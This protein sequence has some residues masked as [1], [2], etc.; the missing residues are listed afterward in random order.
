MQASPQPDSLCPGCGEPAL[1]GNVGG[2]QCVGCDMGCHARPASV[3]FPQKFIKSY[4]SLDSA[5]RLGFGFLCFKCRGTNTPSHSMGSS[6]EVHELQRTFAGLATS[7]RVFVR[8]IAALR[9]EHSNEIAALR[10]EIRCLPSDC[11]QL[12]PDPSDVID[13]VV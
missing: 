8:D 10:E 13:P 2:I 5:S 7:I 1:D 3:G 11:P 12:S 9:S 6:V 4:L